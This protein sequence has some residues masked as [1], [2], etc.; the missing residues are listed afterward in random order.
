MKK[1]IKKRTNK[2]N[3][4][5]KLAAVGLVS[6]LAAS[7]LMAC[8]D[9]EA[10]PQTPVATEEPIEVVVNEPVVEEPVATEEP[11]VEENPYTSENIIELCDELN[12]KYKDIFSDDQLNS[13]VILVNEDHIEED[14]ME[15]IY[16]YYNYSH[17]NI[18]SNFD[19]F[20][21]RMIKM[22]D[23]ADSIE[24]FGNNGDY[25][26]WN[27]YR[28]NTMDFRDF[29]ISDEY[30]EKYIFATGIYERSAVN[31]DYE[32]EVFDGLKET[33]EIASEDYVL[34]LFEASS[35]NGD[36][37]A[38]SEYYAYKDIINQMKNK[39]LSK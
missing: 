29:C 28:Q 1:G 33:G 18:E 15:K 37:K 23:N 20:I 30:K 22:K 16:S 3:L 38:V 2:T 31:N 21:E 19:T 13:I 4:K 5:T 26:L 32:L 11:V 8:N 25:D 14:E 6:G 17:E 39:S 9:V 7:I 12:Q 34:I 35:Y 24:F 10:L 36:K 27:L